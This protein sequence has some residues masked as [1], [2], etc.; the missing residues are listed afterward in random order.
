MRDIHEIQDEAGWNDTTLKDLIL[1]WA[2]TYCH[3]KDLAR[4]LEKQLKEEKEET[5]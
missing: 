4:Y 2:E 5:E 1:Q 3:E